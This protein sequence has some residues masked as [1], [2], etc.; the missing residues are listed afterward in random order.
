[1]TE[2]ICRFAILRYVPDEVRKEFINIGLVFHSPE[3]HYIDIKL[4]NNFSRVHAFDDEVN[5]DFLKLVLDGVKEEFSLAIDINRPLYK[6]LCNWDYLKSA[7]SF[8]NNQL[9]FSDVHTIRSKNIES[10][11]I[12]L[13][14]TYVYFDV[15]KNQRISS[16][17]VKSIMNHVLRD[18]DVISKLKRDI[19]FNIGTEEIIMDYKYESRDKTKVI[20]MF[21]FDYTER[22]SGTAPQVAKEWAWN[23]SKMRNTNVNTEF[24]SAKNLEIVTFVYLGNKNKGKSID[25]A[26][27]ILRGESGELIKADIP[28]DIEIFADKI[29]AEIG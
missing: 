25:V 14:K 13:F 10:D 11:F 19:I 7:T 6:G 4:T 9:Q 15:R 23:F 20:K 18:N 26:L 3:D 24:Q 28:E 17:K 8:Y 12:D 2:K 1:M 22:G 21:S 16:E 27:D 5:I 29:T